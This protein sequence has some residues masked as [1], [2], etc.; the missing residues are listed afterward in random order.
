MK[1]SLST[2]TTFKKGK[3]MKKRMQKRESLF[4]RVGAYLITYEVEIGFVL[5]I[6]ALT[7]VVL[8][9]K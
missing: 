4:S 2:Q 5:A 7:I 1:T 8:V 3:S 9:S 6:I